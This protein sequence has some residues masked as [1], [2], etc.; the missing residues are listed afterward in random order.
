MLYAL[1]A[2]EADFYYKSWK[3]LWKGQHLEE[4]ELLGLLK[5]IDSRCA[6]RRKRMVKDWSRAIAVAGSLYSSIRSSMQLI[7]LSS[8]T[9]IWG[10]QTN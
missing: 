8:T 2:D 4:Y 3:E 7:A 5:K 10:R 9:V 1:L 6:S